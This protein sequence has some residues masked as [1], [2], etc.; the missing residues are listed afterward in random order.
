MHRAWALL[1][2]ASPIDLLGPSAPAPPGL[3]I[4]A[5]M[6]GQ[7]GDE[8][9]RHQDSHA[10]ADHLPLGQGHD[11]TAGRG[12]HQAAAPPRD[13]GRNPAHRHSIITFCRSFSS[14]T[15]RWYCRD[16]VPGFQR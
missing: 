14:S 1:S 10:E 7:K 8:Y 9:G 12:Q 11:T 6:H 4:L 15:R 5:T 3:G 16:Q 13:L 2:I